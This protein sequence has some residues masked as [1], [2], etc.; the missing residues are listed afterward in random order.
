MST[1]RTYAPRKAVRK[2]TTTRARSVRRAAG[3]RKSVS[4]AYRNPFLGSGSF[5]YKPKAGAS[6]ATSRVVGRARTSAPASSA[7]TVG[8]SAPTIKNMPNGN[9]MVTNREYFAEVRTPPLESVGEGSSFFV[10]SYVI[11]AG[12]STVF[13]WLSNLAKSY[14]RYKLAFNLSYESS[15]PTT[16]T[17]SILM[18]YDRNSQ[19]SL[20][21]SKQAMLS[22]QASNTTNLWNAMVFPA[23]GKVLHPS[24]KD[25]F[26]RNAALIEGEDPLQYDMCQVF[27]AIADWL[28]SNENAVQGN[29]YITYTCELLNQKIN[30]DT[31]TVTFANGSSLEATVTPSTSFS[32]PIYSELDYA[33]GLGTPQYFTWTPEGAANPVFGFV[34]PTPGFYEVCQSIVYLGGAETDPAYLV[35][36]DSFDDTTPLIGTGSFG[37]GI[38]MSNVTLV[39]PLVSTEDSLGVGRFSS[40]TNVLQV[41]TSGTFVDGNSLVGTAWIQRPAEWDTQAQDAN[42]GSANNI[43]IRIRQISENEAQWWDGIT[44]APHATT[45]MI[46]EN[47]KRRSRFRDVKTNLRTKRHKTVQLRSL[48]R[49]AKRQKVLPPE[50]QAAE[51]PE[52][53]LRF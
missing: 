16:N 2:T 29:I 25:L 20:P 38:L 8:Y 24:E 49:N 41:L 39:T 44:F 27:V 1:R 17:G 52:L 6:R 50:K 18:A 19:A 47:A 42:M 22:Y 45:S 51:L 7:A 36:P 9:V 46:E 21:A 35:S 30:D 31:N 23:S 12:L 34:F 15:V 3:T 40:T 32:Y 14:T 26:L 4:F 5:S 28:T 43:N 13:P 10:Q 33:F 53:P 48:D 11:N 37:S